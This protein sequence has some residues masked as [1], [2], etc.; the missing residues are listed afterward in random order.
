MPSRHLQSYM[1]G[2]FS[3]HGKYHQVRLGHTA[4]LQSVVKGKAKHLKGKK[5]QKISLGLGPKAPNPTKSFVFFAF[6]ML[7]L[8][9]LAAQQL[10][11]FSKAHCHSGKILGQLSH[12]GKKVL[13]QKS[14]LDKKVLG[15]KS[16]L[17]KKYLG[18]CRLGQLC[19]GQKS[20]WT[21]VPRAKIAAPQI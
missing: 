21:M 15:Q 5:N 10:H 11:C 13:G 14:H 6:Q 16:H 1:P 3:T 20:A 4:S 19:L 18:N 8:S 7:R 2:H 9:P 17:G 12:L